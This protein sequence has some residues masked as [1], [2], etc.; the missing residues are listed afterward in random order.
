M[1]RNVTLLAYIDTDQDG[2]H[3]SP[4]IGLITHGMT[5]RP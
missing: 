5:L 4:S 3:C 2:T 1:T